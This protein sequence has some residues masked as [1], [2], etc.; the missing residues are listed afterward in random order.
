MTLSHDMAKP[1]TALGDRYLDLPV[2]SEYSTLGI[3]TL[4]QHIRCGGLP[5]YKVKGKILIRKSELDAWISSF[6]VNHK[7]DLA[8]I[9]DETVQQL[10]E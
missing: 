5:C 2:A 10:R 8:Q 4:R 1:V 6:R 3:S 7:D 9:V